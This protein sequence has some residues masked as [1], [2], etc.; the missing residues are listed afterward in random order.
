[1]IG[2]DGVGVSFRRLAEAQLPDASFRFA[3]ESVRLRQQNECKFVVLGTPAAIEAHR[4]L[5]IERNQR[6][7][8]VFPRQALLVPAAVRVRADPHLHLC[9]HQ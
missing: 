5:L 1:M 2:L 4:Q 8:P 9:L 6:K 3:P 7:F